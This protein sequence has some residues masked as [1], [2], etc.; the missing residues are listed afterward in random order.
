MTKFVNVT[1]KVPLVPSCP[2]HPSVGL[3]P[4]PR[5]GLGGKLIAGF[6]RCPVD[7]KVY[8]ERPDGAP[9]PF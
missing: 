4:E 2:G 6:W 1:G 9:N 3:I 8:Q 7:N 5:P